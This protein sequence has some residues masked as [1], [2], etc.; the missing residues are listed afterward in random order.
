MCQIVDER[1][2]PAESI[3]SQRLL[4]LCKMLRVLMEQAHHAAA[5]SPM[6]PLPRQLR[7]NLSERPGLENVFPGSVITVYD[8]FRSAR[9]RLLFDTCCVKILDT[10]ISIHTHDFSS[11]HI[12]SSNVDLARDFLLAAQPDLVEL[13]A[14]Y[15]SILSV[16]PV[17]IG[18]VTA[19]GAT[20]VDPLILN[21]TGILTVQS[22]LKTIRRSEYVSQG[23]RA[24][25][26]AVLEFL[27][28]HKH[29]L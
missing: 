15:R 4:G 13:E 3:D 20:K 9:D 11:Q 17:L 7:S 5:R 26:N 14:R 2:K 28:T 24:E 27:D 21:D 8:D 16:V 18:I 12:S 29:V 23:L 25:A 6:L 10:L 1:G 22:P 19:R